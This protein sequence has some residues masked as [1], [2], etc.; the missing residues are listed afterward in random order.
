MNTSERKK[1][2]VARGELS[3]HCHVITGEVE[4]DS[5][6]RIIVGENAN[7]AIKHL[8]ESAWLA[9]EEKWTTEHHDIALSPGIYKYVPQLVLD[10]L[11]QRIEKARD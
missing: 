3:D 9:G 2:I 11:S 10:P 7:A 1:R 6:G 5:Q 8:I 4:F